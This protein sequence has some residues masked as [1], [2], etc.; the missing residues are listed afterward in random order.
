MD[1][2]QIFRDVG[3]LIHEQG[4]VIGDCLSVAHSIQF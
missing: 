4:D 2:N 3:M 1:V